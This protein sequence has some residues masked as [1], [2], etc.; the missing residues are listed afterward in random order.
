MAPSYML[1]IVVER[2]GLVILLMR[3][4]VEPW[5]LAINIAIVAKCHSMEL[6]CGPSNVGSC[7]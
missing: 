4:S 6:S 3:R 2:A 5:S 1:Y 7:E